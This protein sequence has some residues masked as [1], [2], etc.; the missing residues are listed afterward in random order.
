MMM[1]KVRLVHDPKVTAAFQIEEEGQLDGQWF[2]LRMFS[3]EHEA[4]NLLASIKK[5]GTGKRVLEVIEVETN[6]G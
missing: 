5:H 4:R 6:H 3:N 2:L 1:T